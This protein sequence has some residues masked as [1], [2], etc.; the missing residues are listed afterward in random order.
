MFDSLKQGL[1]IWRKLDGNCCLMECIVCIY[2]YK[3]KQCKSIAD[4]LCWRW[5][6]K[7]D[8]NSSLHTQCKSG[9]SRFGLKLVQIG[10]TWDKSWNFK[11][12][13]SIHFSTPNLTS[14]VQMRESNGLQ[15]RQIF[16]LNKLWIQTFAHSDKMYK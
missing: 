16:D 3:T 14:L 7:T 4:N 5:Q 9:M 10:T 8:F 2:K 15:T 12:Q 11:D 13:F 1:L 6:T